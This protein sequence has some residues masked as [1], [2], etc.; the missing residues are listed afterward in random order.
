MLPFGRGTL[1]GGFRC[2]FIVPLN[3][4]Y[5]AALLFSKLLQMRTLAFL[6]LIS[7]TAR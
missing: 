1:N 6:D 5:I 3:P 4:A 7:S 2:Y